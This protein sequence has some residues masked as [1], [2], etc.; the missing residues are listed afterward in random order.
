[1]A[2]VNQA[3]AH[4]KR[5]PHI[6]SIS[7]AERWSFPSHISMRRSAQGIDAPLDHRISLYSV[8][9]APLVEMPLLEIRM[10]FERKRTPRR[11]HRSQDEVSSGRVEPFLNEDQRRPG[12]IMS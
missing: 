3:K 11:V 12:R 4:E 5:L 2:T 10:F 9:C 1:Q 6:G 7:S 8:S